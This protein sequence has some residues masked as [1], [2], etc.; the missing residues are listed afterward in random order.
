VPFL[1]AKK[2]IMQAKRQQPH[3]KKKK[4]KGIGEMKDFHRK[5]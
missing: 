2:Q 3:I 5:N 1:A 4:E